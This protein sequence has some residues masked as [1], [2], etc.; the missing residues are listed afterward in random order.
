M[1]DA[2]EGAECSDSSA[3]GEG[4]QVLA[5][6]A[7]EAHSAALHSVYT[8]ELCRS[9]PHPYWAAILH[10]GANVRLVQ[11][12]NGPLAEYESGSADDAKDAPA[13]FV[14]VSYMHGPGEISLKGYYF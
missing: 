9:I 7:H 3:V 12:S 11:K 10:S 5:P 6:W 13:F 1:D 2:V 14:D 4:M 8:A